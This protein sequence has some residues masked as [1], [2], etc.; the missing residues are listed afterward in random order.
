MRVFNKVFCSDRIT[1]ERAYGQMTRK[2]LILW[3]ESPLKTLKDINLSFSVCVKEHNL[4]VDEWLCKRLILLIFVYTYI[5]FYINFTITFILYRM[6]NK[7]L[8]IL[9]KKANLVQHILIQDFPEHLK[10]SKLAH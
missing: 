3:S 6:I 4:N 1:V 2:F 10:S 9:L 7:D 8:D 5:I